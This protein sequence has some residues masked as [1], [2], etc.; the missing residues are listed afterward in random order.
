MDET[1]R[2]LLE[3][4][5][6]S[7]LM[8]DLAYSS[9]LFNSVEIAEEVLFLQVSLNEMA[10]SIEESILSME[11]SREGL[12]KAMVLLKLMMAIEKIGDSAAS[13]ADV[14]V[15]GLSQHPVMSMSLKDS[16]VLA[17]RVDVAP[18]AVLDGK[19]L[20]EI[21]LASRTGMFVIAIKRG[22]RY[23][24]GPGKDTVIQE[25]DTLIA[26][27]PEDGS[28]IFRKMADGSMDPESE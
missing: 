15:R 20:G 12:V 19:S 26:R 24:Y 25:G 4:K 9:V 21:R 8:I 3:L 10:D 11:P 2:I 23:I 1:E 5:N 17:E 27:G 6:T 22:R 18:G 14:V 7:E 13:I 16:D 28:E